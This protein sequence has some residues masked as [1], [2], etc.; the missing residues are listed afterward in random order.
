MG[1]YSDA[2]DKIVVHLQ[3]LYKKHRT[4]D[5][6]VADLGKA[7]NSDREIRVLKTKKLWYKDEI[8]RLENELKMLGNG[9]L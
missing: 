7:F 3:E 5:H 9:N 4:L 6:E 2:H 1:N 8:N